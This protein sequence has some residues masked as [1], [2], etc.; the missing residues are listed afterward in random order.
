MPQRVTL[1]PKVRLI[2]IVPPNNFSLPV[3][4]VLLI[5]LENAVIMKS[6]QKLK[7]LTLGALLSAIG[8]QAATLPIH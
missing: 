1:K 5:N 4:S 7:R 8:L 6:I 3:L 2:G